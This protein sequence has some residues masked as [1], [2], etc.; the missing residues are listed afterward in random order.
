MSTVVTEPEG[1]DRTGRAGQLPQCPHEE[2]AAQ[3]CTCCSFWG[4]L[5]ERVS[6]PAHQLPNEPSPLDC[7]PLA[8]LG[9]SGAHLDNEASGRTL[10]DPQ[11][12]FPFFPLSEF[13]LRARGNE[14][15]VLVNQGFV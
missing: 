6:E 7:P 10:P 2:G 1:L 3:A 14:H 15:R 9:P 11:A 4:R 12:E 13:P 8:S 5:R